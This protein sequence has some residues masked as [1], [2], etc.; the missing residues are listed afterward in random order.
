MARRALK[1]IELTDKLTL[2][3]CDDGFWLYDYDAEMNL[4]MRANSEREALLEAITYYKS[5]A[6]ELKRILDK[7]DKA[8]EQF[9]SSVDE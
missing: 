9:I 4:S 7:Q 3:E 6:K 1:H 8:I 5:K 2:S